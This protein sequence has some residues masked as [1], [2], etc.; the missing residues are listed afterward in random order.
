MEGYFI[1]KLGL[2]ILIIG[3][4]RLFSNA[5]KGLPLVIPV[6]QETELVVV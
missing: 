4:Y 3:A 1:H 5:H 6:P 2:L